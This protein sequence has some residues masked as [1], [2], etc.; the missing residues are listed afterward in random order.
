[1][2]KTVKFK[3]NIN[4]LIPSILLTLLGFVG[5]FFVKG[6][7]EKEVK[8]LK[9]IYIEKKDEEVRQSI[10]KI[11]DHFYTIYQSLRM[12]SLFPGIRVIDRYATNLDQN[13]KGAIQQI[14]NNTFLSTYISEIYILPK[15]FNPEKIDPKTGIMESP[16]TTFDEFIVG[17]TGGNESG[18]KITHLPEEEIYEYREMVKQL[19]HFKLNYPRNHVM[20]LEAVPIHISKEVVTCDNS[21]FSLKDLKESNNKPRN[22]YV[23]T[24]PTYDYDGKFYGGIS[25]VFRSD[26]LKNL[27]ISR[28][29]G[30]V[31]RNKKIEITNKPSRL[32]VETAFKYFENGQLNPDLIY[33]KIIKLNIKDVTPWSIWVAFD[34]NDFYLW[35]RYLQMKRSTKVSIIILIIIVMV[36]LYFGSKNIKMN[37]SLEDKVIS[38]T[39]YLEIEKIR[40]EKA[41]HLKTEFLAKMSHEIRTPLNGVL[42]GTQILL[43]GYK[44]GK[45]EKNI[46]EI[47]FKSA[48][49]LKNTINEILDLSK[50]KEKKIIINESRF[51]LSEM[52]QEIIEAFKGSRNE[53]SFIIGKNTPSE[54]ITDRDI[55][56][57]ILINLVSNSDKFTT[58]GKIKI[59]VD[60]EEETSIGIKLKFVIKDNGKGMAKNEMIKVFSPFSFE[61]ANTKSFGDPGLGL[62]IV[63]EAVGLLKGDIYILSEEGEGTSVV[64]TVLV[65]DSKGR[66]ELVFSNK[67]KRNVKIPIIELVEKVLWIEDDNHSKKLVET[68]LKKES[69]KNLDW[70]NNGEDV[71]EAIK[72][73]QYRFIFLSLKTPRINSLELIKNIKDIDFKIR[74]K[75]IIVAAD[76]SQETKRKCVEAGV[77]RFLEKPIDFFELDEILKGKG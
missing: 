75:I 68:V 65:G 49:N 67:G 31:N 58:D 76:N 3:K 13:S 70:L 64:F 33:N 39:K 54:V 73:Y 42:G 12:M 30:L 8:E 21:N 32:W 25:A 43:N 66:G 28:S 14:Y 35:D 19:N 4:F 71:L 18:E 36:S 44:I 6:Q 46:L 17:K 69:L 52:I 5:L 1:M 22:G 51:N 9:N 38:K 11:E 55:M 29:L 63:K 40:A 37:S 45:N 56:D 16:I 48:E 24:V 50:F 2:F 41:S 10:S 20:D 61:E 23:V 27:L 60:K 72:K 53:I 34:N 59:R 7:Y 74:P 57:R 77:D 26:I 62:S 15:I 47:I